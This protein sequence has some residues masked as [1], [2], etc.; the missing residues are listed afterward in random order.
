VRIGPLDNAE[1]M[2]AVEAVIRAHGGDPHDRSADVHSL[3]ELE[4]AITHYVRMTH[5]T[6]YNC[7][8]CGEVI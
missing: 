7:P 3:R 8:F 6:H 5:E 4:D 1:I 2:R